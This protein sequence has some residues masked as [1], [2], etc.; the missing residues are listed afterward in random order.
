M[1]TLIDFELYSDDFEWDYKLHFPIPTLN[2][3]KQR[4]GE[5]LTMKFDTELL[6]KGALITVIRTAKGYLFRDRLDM[7]EWEWLIAHDIKLLYDVLE[8]LMSFVDFAFISGNYTELHN[9][10]RNSK[11][12]PLLEYARSIVSGA[13]KALYGVR[14][15][16]ENY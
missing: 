1:A 9:L 13:R 16:R 14:D 3:I 7:Y 4:T 8:Y 11:D 15:F 2:Y 10:D 6:A 5:D 12:A